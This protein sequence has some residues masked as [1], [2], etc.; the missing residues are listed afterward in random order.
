MATAR[1]LDL[2]RRHRHRFHVL[3]VSTAAE[4]PL[5]EDHAGLVTAEVCLHHLC[6]DV[7]DYARLGTRI[8]MNPSVKGREDRLALWNALGR[9]VDPDPGDGPCPSHPRGEGLPLP[10]LLLQDCRP[11]R[12]RFLSCCTRSTGDAAP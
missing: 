6:F 5:L 12:T 11:S 8:Q 9:G 7:S 2:A 4:I 10:I 3:H 1:A